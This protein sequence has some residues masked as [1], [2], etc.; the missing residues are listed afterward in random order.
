MIS[1][2]NKQPHKKRIILISLL[3]VALVLAS[4]GAFLYFKQTQNKAVNI[5]P[6]KDTQQINTDIQPADNVDTKTPAQTT[7]P[8]KSTSD[9]I[10]ASIT[11]LSQNTTNLEV[12][13]LINI[14]LSE[15]ECKLSLT[16][17]STNIQKSSGIQASSSSST[18]QGFS[19][20]LSELSAGSWNASIVITSAG[21]TTTLSRDFSIK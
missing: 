1:I 15:G 18:C 11:A 12:R 2:Q 13:V 8:T 20:P 3:A 4:V 6:A 14:I 10:P 19:I 9:D 21:K 7:E 16:K 5:S 17:G